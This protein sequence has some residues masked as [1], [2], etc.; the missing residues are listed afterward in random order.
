MIKQTTTLKM[1]TLVFSLSSIIG[2]T[3]NEN[4]IP[5]DLLGNWKVISFD[6]NVSMTKIFKTSSNTWSN[7][8]N[9]DNTVTF[10]KAGSKTVEMSGINVTNTFT[11][12]FDI[13]P[14]DKINMKDGGLWTFVGEPE[15]GSLFRSIGSS[16]SFELSGDNLVI[17]YNQKNNSISLV[18]STI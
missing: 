14:G 13:S 11:G 10:Q 7:F 4:V 8:N 3:K 18:R 6:D 17:F 2:C 12:Y 9:G 15:W 1:L 5:N 16:E